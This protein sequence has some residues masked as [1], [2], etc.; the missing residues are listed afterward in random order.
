MQN[1]RDTVIIE[2]EMISKITPNCNPPYILMPT[3]IAAIKTLHQLETEQMTDDALQNKIMRIPIISDYICT[4][5]SLQSFRQSVAW[6]LKDNF[7]G[8][9]LNLYRQEIQLLQYFLLTIYNITHPN[10]LIL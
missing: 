10:K 9:L 6:Q 5:G 7:F 8:R 4:V 3:K 1:L 2:E